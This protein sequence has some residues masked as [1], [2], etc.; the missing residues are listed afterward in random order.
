MTSSRPHLAR[1]CFA[2]SDAVLNRRNVF[3]G[4]LQSGW[5]EPGP[6]KLLLVVN[7]LSSSKV[8]QHDPWGCLFP[9]LTPTVLLQE[10]DFRVVR[11]CCLHSG[12]CCFVEQVSGMF[13]VLFTF[14]STSLP[15]WLGGAESDS[16][17]VKTKDLIAFPGNTAWSQ[18]FLRSPTYQAPQKPALVTLGGVRKPN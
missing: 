1:I 14:K 13:D 4:I 5:L 6:A 16:P 8:V 12:A 7:P 11:L 18:I 15:V 2:A 9:A 17:A 3:Y 10:V